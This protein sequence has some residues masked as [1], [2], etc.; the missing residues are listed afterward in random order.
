ME[1][2][3]VNEPGA[4]KESIQL[5]TLA[6]FDQTYAYEEQ[7]ASQAEL[8]G[9]KHVQLRATLPDLMTGTL[10]FDQM[11][12]QD[13]QMETSQH[14]LY[15]IHKPSLAGTVEG[16][17]CQELVSFG[18]AAIDSTGHSTVHGNSHF[19]RYRTL[20]NL[21]ARSSMRIPLRPDSKGEAPPLKRTPSVDAIE[22]V[23][24]PRP[25]G[26]HV[27][28][29]ECLSDNGQLVAQLHTFPLDI[30]SNQVP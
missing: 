1:G 12:L 18:N 13:Y 28:G 16:N 30:N 21:R 24:W 27:F 29:Q 6:N 2:E 4:E 25:G 15:I 10:G 26:E 7:S 9:L 19:D 3:V 22:M 17:M 8:S 5:F 14:N 20:P 23:P 11:P